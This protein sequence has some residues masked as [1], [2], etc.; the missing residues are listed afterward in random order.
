MA[1]KRENYEEIEKI[2]AAKAAK[3]EKK[4]KAKMNVS[5]KGVFKLREIIVQKSKSR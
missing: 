2:A 4:K 3:R 1:R 5:G